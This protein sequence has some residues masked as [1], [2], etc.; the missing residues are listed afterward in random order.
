V[1]TN[2]FFEYTIDLP[3]A[4]ISRVGQN[5]VGF[6]DRFDRLAKNLVLISDPELL[7]AWSREHY[8]VV[9]PI[10]QRT[11]ERYPLA[12]FV[13]DV[14][15]G[16][17]AFARCA[18]NR[19]TQQLKKQ[20]TLFALS[21][22]VRGEGR[23]GEASSRINAA[24]TLVSESLGKTK[25][26]FVLIDEADSLVTTRAE[27]HAHLE[28]KV[29]VNTIVQKVDDLRRHGGRL[30]V[31][32]ATNRPATLD[33]A[34]IRRAALIEVFERPNAAEREELLRLDL[35]ELGLKAETICAIVDMTGPRNGNPG[36]TFSDL[37]TRF[38][39]EIL[40]RAYPT[41]RVTDDDALEAAGA[42][43]PSPEAS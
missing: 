8:R 32:L 18:A 5:L 13:G 41:R 42:V 30:V 38:L 24:F 17:T 3:D 14:G 10:V 16:K 6:D 37:R 1:I 28:D 34:V 43:S 9:A 40:I 25:L 4:D 33:P 7:S 23:V 29:A 20:G 26:C 35:A 22:R 12:I 36:F 21:T 2:E 19:V 31:F 11:S 27:A 39:P 15:T